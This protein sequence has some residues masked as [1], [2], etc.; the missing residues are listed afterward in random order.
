[1]I[2]CSTVTIENPGLSACEADTNYSDCGY[3][4][5]GGYATLPNS[6]VGVFN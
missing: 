3:V 4:V 1:V 5:S 6:C 2:D